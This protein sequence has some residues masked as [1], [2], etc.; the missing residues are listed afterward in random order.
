ML[1]KDKK[2]PKLSGPCSV[3]LAETCYND[4]TILVGLWVKNWM[5]MDWYCDVFTLCLVN[6]TD[7][8]KRRPSK[9]DR[10]LPIKTQIW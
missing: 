7:E 6:I 2:L 9:I 10:K 4:V 5:F 3:L 1:N 8:I